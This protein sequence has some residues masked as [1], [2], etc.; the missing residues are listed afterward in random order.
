MIKSMIKYKLYKERLIIQIT[1]LAKIISV[2]LSLFD[3]S[4]E[5]LKEHYSAEIEVKKKLNRV[6]CQ[7]SIDKLKEVSWYNANRKNVKPLF[8]L[9]IVT[10]KAASTTAAGTTTTTTTPTQHQQQQQQQQQ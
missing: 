6:Y 3:S 1:T 10:N 2:T 8:T 9:V 7:V 4:C 5:Y